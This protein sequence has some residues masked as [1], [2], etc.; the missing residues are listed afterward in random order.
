MSYNQRQGG[1]TLPTIAPCQY[2]SWWRE[3]QLR[4]ERQRVRS[5]VRSD[6][7]LPSTPPSA[8]FD[9]KQSHLVEPRQ[10]TTDLEKGLQH[11]H[12]ENDLQSRTSSTFLLSTAALQRKQVLPKHP[13]LPPERYPRII[14]HLCYTIFAVYQRLFTLIFLINLVLVL[15]LLHC[16]LWQSSKAFSLE[17]LAT[18][19]SSNFLLAILFR[20]DWIV[21]L[22][23]RSAWLVP[24]SLPLRVRRVVSRVYCYGGIHSGAAVMG[25]VWWLW[26]TAVLSWQGATQGNYTPLILILALVISSLLVT[27]VILSLPRLRVRH[28][29]TWEFTH[30]FMGW[31]SI[32]LF[33][34]QI[35]LLTH[36]NTISPVAEQGF[37]HLLIKTPTFWNLVAIS[38]LLVYP[39]LLLRRWTFTATPL[40]HHALQLSFSNKVHKYSCL[41]LSSSPL[42]EWHPFA[43]FPNLDANGSK[44]GNSMVV[45]SAGDWTKGLVTTTQRRCQQQQSVQGSEKE[46]SVQMSFYV[47]S[48][49]R[50]GVLS[51]S[52][53]YKRVVII[54]TGS[55]IGPSLSSL[56]DRPAGQEARLVWSTRSPLATYGAGIMSLVER[57]DPE[58]I[59]LDTD[60]MGRPDLLAVAWRVYKKMDAEAVFVLSNEKLTRMVV[61]GLEGR[62]VPAYGPIWD[63]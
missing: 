47:K 14:R 34:A 22:L 39:W 52:C 40:S 44:Q 38:L 7:I 31:L 36:Y 37:G 17:N 8:V 32:A 49:P 5:P 33:W 28:H 61:G 4:S 41:T 46:G 12:S 54:T 42:R 26:F 59:V 21:N 10:R 50:A 29:D 55:G 62:G 23:F 16:Q 19:A 11:S 57:A 56:L 27:I 53:L 25:T 2:R 18:L 51:L 35:L 45:S 20:Q 6:S 13:N 43:T 63:S 15:I 30:R 48:H 9:R 24:W 60:E 1:A 3:R 58:A